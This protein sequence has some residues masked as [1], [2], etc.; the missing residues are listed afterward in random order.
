MKI[1]NNT[2]METDHN[3]VITYRLHHTTVVTV[4]PSGCVRFS[5]GGWQTV[6][7]KNRLNRYGCGYCI[8][9]RAGEWFVS[10]PQIP[11]DVPFFD[12]ITL[13]I[14]EETSA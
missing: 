12:G 6:T 1:A 4:F 10:H 7:T 14:L 5:S 9:Q 8:Y 3:G 13:P 2:Y 11:R